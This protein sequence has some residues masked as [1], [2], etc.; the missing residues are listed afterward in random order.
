MKRHIEIVHESKTY[1]FSQ[2]GKQLGP[3]SAVSQHVETIHE[4]KKETFNCEYCDK[5]F[6]T[7]SNLNRHC[8]SH[9][10]IIM[11]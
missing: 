7:K 3:P 10:K 8:F 6:S 1:P 2:C 11:G 4:N 5:S 9:H